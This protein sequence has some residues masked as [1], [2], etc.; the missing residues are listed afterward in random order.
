MF[1]LHQRARKHELH[2]ISLPTLK[3]KLLSSQ[4]W[5]AIA[6][7]NGEAYSIHLFE[8]KI[9]VESIEPWQ[10]NLGI[11]PFGSPWLALRM[12]LMIDNIKKIVE[13]AMMVYGKNM[14]YATG[15][16]DWVDLRARRR[17]AD[18]SRGSNFKRRRF[19]DKPRQGR[20]LKHLFVRSKK[21]PTIGVN[22][23]YATSSMMETGLSLRSSSVKCGETG[24]WL[25]MNL[26]DYWWW[27]T[28]L[29][30]IPPVVML[31]S[32]SRSG[33]FFK[34]ALWLHSVVMEGTSQT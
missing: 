30:L 34:D 15:F 10:M 27:G 18:F 16:C 2:P 4:N 20:D 29:V 14:K 3:E 19:W 21:C 24:T 26:S 11:L 25:P 1:F 28:I 7:N 12:H 9:I 6:G 17:Y 8:M 22:V 5:R 13:L 33:A 31:L 32:S 23:A